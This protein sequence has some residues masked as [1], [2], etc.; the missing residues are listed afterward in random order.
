MFTAFSTEIVQDGH[1]SA[2]PKKPVSGIAADESSATC[3]QNVH[4]RS[5]SLYELR[6][7]YL[8]VTTRW[9]LKKYP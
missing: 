6:N 7:S 8:S 1:V 5:S 4:A 3:D 9:G 2:I